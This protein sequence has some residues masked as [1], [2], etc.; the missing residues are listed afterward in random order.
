M[1]TAWMAIASV[2]RAMRVRT[3]LS[4]PAQPTVTTMAVASMACA[5]VMRDLRAV[6]AE[7]KDAQATA[8]EWVS[9]WMDGASVM[10]VTLARTVQKVRK[11]AMAT[12]S[13]HMD[14]S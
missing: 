7:R 14:N 3:A 6:I 11:N 10:R 8:M 2:K 9:V 12:S 13:I 5:S 4:S 1:D